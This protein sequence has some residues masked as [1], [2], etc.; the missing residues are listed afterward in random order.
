MVFIRAKQRAKD[1]IQLAHRTMTADARC[2]SGDTPSIIMFC[3]APSCHFKRVVRRALTMEVV[4]HHVGS[5]SIGQARGGGAT[6]VEGEG[7]GHLNL[8]R[9]LM[10]SLTVG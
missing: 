5:I 10:M 9:P 2:W 8:P 4:S 6:V 7:D 3:G 1:H